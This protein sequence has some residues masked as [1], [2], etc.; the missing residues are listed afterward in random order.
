MIMFKTTVIR[1]S[2]K[3]IQDEYIS[4]FY[5]LQKIFTFFQNGIFETDFKD[6][7]FPWYSS[8]LP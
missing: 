1:V 2:R 3:S 4:E 6:P 7:Q 8:L 5:P